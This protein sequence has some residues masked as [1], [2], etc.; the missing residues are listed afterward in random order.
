MS[1]YVSSTIMMLFVFKSLI[2]LLLL[3]VVIFSSRLCAETSFEGCRFFPAIDNDLSAIVKNNN[4]T[5]F[6]N[7]STNPPFIIFQAINFL[8]F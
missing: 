3:Y 6:N 7:K 4:T 8:M 5:L 1:S 2:S